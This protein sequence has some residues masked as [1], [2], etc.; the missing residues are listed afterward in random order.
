ML[1][2]ST[3][4]KL[5]LLNEKEIT[6]FSIPF[7]R[8]VSCPKHRKILFSITPISTATWRTGAL[9]SWWVCHLFVAILEALSCLC[10]C[11]I[12]R[13]RG[14]RWTG[15]SSEHLSSVHVASSR[16]R[17]SFQRF[18]LQSWFTLNNQLTCS[19]WKKTPFH[20]LPEIK[21][22]IATKF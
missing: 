18:L 11:V 6:L 4:A 3:A 1:L 16:V 7:S 8:N 20:P 10:V 19:T 2:C 13:E 22:S 17:V 9:M 15:R 21:K 14:S 12:R 5:E